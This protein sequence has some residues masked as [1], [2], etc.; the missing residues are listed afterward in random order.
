MHQYSLVEQVKILEVGK[1]LIEEW[2][3]T[4]PIAHRA[5][6]YGINKETFIALK[7]VEIPIDSSICHG[8]LNCKLEKITVNKIMSIANVIEVPITTMEIRPFITFGPFAMYSKNRIYK[9]DIERLS[10][11]NLFSFAHQAKDLNISIMTLTLHSHSFIT[12][13]PNFSDIELN[14]ENLSKFELFLNSITQN[15]HFRSMTFK[16]FYGEYSVFPSKFNGSN[17][18]PYVERKV[19]LKEVLGSFYKKNLQ[20]Q[21]IDPKLKKYWEQFSQEKTL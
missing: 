15:K 4:S 20:K 21:K 5:G 7:N 14:K 1:S 18:I 12:F 16:E 11:E 13:S 6:G 9:T 8:W 3:G 19:K 17:E 10:L 2:T